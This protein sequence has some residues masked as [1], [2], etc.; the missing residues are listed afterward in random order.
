MKKRNAIEMEQEQS[1]NSDQGL[2]L[3]SFRLIE[4]LIAVAV[5]IGCAPRSTEKSLLQAAKKIWKPSSH[6]W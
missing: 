2:K 3:P 4:L 6:A 5:S 1:L